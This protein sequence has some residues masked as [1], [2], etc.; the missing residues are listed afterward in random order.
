MKK[1]LAIMLASALAAATLAGCTDGTNHD[2]E[3]TDPVIS[4]VED[5]ATTV[6]G[7]EFDAASACVPFPK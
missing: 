4:G 7:E 2:Q 3:N 1:K 6:A 5:T